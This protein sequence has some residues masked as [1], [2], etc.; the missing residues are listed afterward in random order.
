[1]NA[2]DVRANTDALDPP[3]LDP[4]SIVSHRGPVRLSGIAV[5]TAIATVALAPAARGDT[6]IQPLQR[7]RSLAQ[8]GGWLAWAQPTGPFGHWQLALRSPSGVT[9]MPAIPDFPVDPDPNIGSDRFGINGRRLFVVYSRCPDYDHCDVYRYDI[10]AGT[11]AKVTAISTAAGKETAPSLRSGLW[12]F[13]R[14]GAGVPRSRRGVYAYTPGGGVRQLSSVVA[15]E[16]TL[17]A[18]RVAYSYR[19]E[20]GGGVAVRRLSGE[21]GVVNAVAGKRLA[22]FSLVATRYRFAWLEGLTTG[23]FRVRQT[24]RLSGR[25]TSVTVQSGKRNLSSMTNSITT[26]DRTPDKYLDAAGIWTLNPPLFF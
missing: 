13:V 20:K 14:R 19:S 24:S 22:P 12:A 17:S 3:G 7:S 1:M 26:N 5:L 18:S 9:T 25:A 16:T 21:G 6:L 4:Q 11:E 8:G 2:D 23:G 15:R 10:T